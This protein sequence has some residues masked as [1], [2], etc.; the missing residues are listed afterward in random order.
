MDLYRELFARFRALETN[1]CSGTVSNAEAEAFL[2]E[3]APRFACSDETLTEIFAFR[4][5]TFRK[6]LRATPD[7]FVITEFLPDVPWAGAYNAI[8][9]PV[10]HHINEGRWL[11][12]RRYIKEDILHFLCGA[13][14]EDVFSYQNDLIFAACDYVL[15]FGDLA[16]GAQILDDLVRVYRTW[17]ER[18]G[19]STGLLWCVDDTDGMEYSISGS[20]LR[21]TL[22]AYMYGAAYGLARLCEQLGRTDEARTFRA[23]AEALRESI[24]RYLWD[25]RDGFYKTVPQ[26][27]RDGI[28]DL[29]RKNSARDVRELI[30]YL[31]FAYPA[32]V[33]EGKDGAFAALTDPD[34]FMAPYGLT[35]AD[36]SHPRF[37]RTE[38][39]H[40]C[41]WDGP[42]WPFAT[43][44]TLSA[45]IRHRERG[46]I[47]TFPDECFVQALMTYA[48][49]HYLTEDGV[50]VPWIDEDMDP[51][52]GEW[53]ARRMLHELND[54]LAE[55]GV[56]YN[57]SSFCDLVIRGLCG[58]RPMGDHVELCPMLSDSIRWLLLEN[59]H[60]FGKTYAV[61]YDADGTHLGRGKGLFLEE[62]ADFAN[63]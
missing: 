19:T 4:L 3:G 60:L 48:R 39:D 35:T 14:R 6:H 2:C 26:D 54:P 61:Y 58:V 55:R 11:R 46:E 31:P 16:F 7:G 5:W 1:E 33:G 17:W 34:C 38:V 42:V 44:Q 28:A 25:A 37:R 52:T 51:D 57:H 49:S 53:V 40:E 24:E 12:D 27:T 32:L 30:G 56:W 43:A 9:C 13:G 47:P 29:T 36:R 23:E 21:P 10:G 62:T 20:G 45:V 63:I 15:S 59:L 41:L 18:N 50:R 8:V 22:N